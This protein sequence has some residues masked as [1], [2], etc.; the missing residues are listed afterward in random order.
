MFIL[1]RSIFCYQCVFA[2]IWLDLVFQY[3]AKRLAGKHIS[4]MTYFVFFN[5]ISQLVNF[6]MQYWPA[7]SVCKSA[8]GPVT[9]EM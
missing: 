7:L 1:C 3:E 8:I 5:S 6:V 2:F 4:E 9:A